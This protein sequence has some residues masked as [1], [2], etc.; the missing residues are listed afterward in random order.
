MLCL[1]LVYSY[2]YMYVYALIVCTLLL[3]G[4]KGIYLSIWKYSHPDVGHV[5]NRKFNAKLISTGH[6]LFHAQK[7]RKSNVSNIFETDQNEMLV[8]FHKHRLDRFFTTAIVQCPIVRV[9]SGFDD[10]SI[11]LL[12]FS[13]GIYILHSYILIAFCML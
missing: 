6:V 9:S 5:T 2:M 7:Y 1:S 11:P 13:I 12:M 10:S 8:I 3:G 4:N